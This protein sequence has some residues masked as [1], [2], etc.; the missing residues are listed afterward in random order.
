M[1][2]L[3]RTIISLS[4]CGTLLMLLILAL[5]R[6][7]RN[8]FRKC[9][10][11]YILLAAALRFLMPFTMD[12]AVVGRLL[13]SADLGITSTDGGAAILATEATN[14]L[15]LTDVGADTKKIPQIQDALKYNSG[16][17]KR[18]PALFYNSGLIKWIPALFYNSGITKWIP[19]LF[20]IWA[21]GVLV[22]LVRKITI[23]QSFVQY[24]KAGSCAVTDM[25]T[26]N[27]LSDCEERYRI[28]KPIELFRNPLAASPMMIGFFHPSI[29]L[30]NREIA[31]GRLVYIFSH[32]LIHYRRRD[33]FYKWLI[34][35][36]VCV[37]WFNPF[38]CLLVKEIN[39]LCELA[40]DE[41]VINTLDNK[42]RKEYGDT[43]LSFFHAGN[44]YGNTLASV[45]LTESAAQLKERLGAIMSKKKKSKVITA[46]T[47]LATAGICICFTAAGA[48]AAPM[49]MQEARNKNAAEWGRMEQKT[50]NQDMEQELV[51]QAIME[52][53][54][55][56]QEIAEQTTIEQET[57]EQEVPDAPDSGR[58]FDKIRIYK[59]EGYYW[60][61]YVIQ[62]SWNY[63]KESNTNTNK[64]APV[65]QALT[66]EDGTVI[67]VYFADSIG[68]LRNNG[69]VVNAVAGLIYYVKSSNTIPQ[70][71]VPKIEKIEYVEEKNIAKMAEQYYK[72]KELC[73]FFALFTYLDKAQQEQYFEKIYQAE[74]E[75]FFAC[76]I[77]YMDKEMLEE[78]VKRSE[79]VDRID[80]F[81]I[82]LDYMEVNTM[83]EY[84]KRFYQEDKME[85]FSVIMAY[86][87]EEERQEWLI[88]ARKDKKKDFEAVLSCY[89]F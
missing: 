71:Q 81:S 2:E 72:N 85:W 66:L 14:S 57:A 80:F 18:I 19:V 32:E 30:P 17:V 50:A 42:E 89:E 7:V 28:S 79:Q 55:M 6:I 84:A 13:Q 40:C 49:D 82:M 26:L 88:K 48:Y 69:D 36:V 59:E 76:A 58:H 44:G 34:Q 56:E 5:N 21:A 78:Y 27:I 24:M 35:I 4:C 29:I 39:R 37:H 51:K 45:T 54:I 63:S 23:Y 77:T 38:V 16:I 83:K 33:I 3:I 8:K 65:P 22:L 10:Q 53:D 41:A 62:M 20:Y 52:Q 70:L 46:V 43:L 31:A 61:S 25:E 64:N 75:D 73:S 9:W 15:R 74:Q 12:T 47:V 86:M 1:T 87:T 11:Y 67:T 68:A 60:N